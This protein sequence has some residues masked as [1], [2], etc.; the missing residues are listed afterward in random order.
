[1]LWLGGEDGFED[2]FIIRFA[3][4]PTSPS[5]LVQLIVGQIETLSD[6]E[7]LGPGEF[8]SLIQHLEAALGALEHENRSAA[9]RALE[10]FIRKV[11]AMARRG[12]LSASESGALIAAANDVIAKL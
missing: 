11:D 9:R 2:A 7:R 8:N 4:E 5:G 6:R 10:S 3:L 12:T 1:M